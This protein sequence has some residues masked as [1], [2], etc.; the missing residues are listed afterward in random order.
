MFRSRYDYSRDD[1]LRWLESGVDYFY[2]KIFSMESS[3]INSWWGFGRILAWTP[4]NIANLEEFKEYFSVA[5]NRL[6]EKNLKFQ[7]VNYHGKPKKHDERALR[8]FS[9]YSFMLTQ[10]GKNETIDIINLYNKELNHHAR[11]RALIMAMSM[12]SDRN[13]AVEIFK[14]FYRIF[15]DRHIEI[16]FRLAPKGFADP[17]INKV[18][19]KTKLFDHL[20]FDKQSVESD[21]EIKNLLIKK[22]AQTPSLIEKLTFDINITY[23]NIENLPPVLRFNFIQRLFKCEIDTTRRGWGWTIGDGLQKRIQWKRK[24]TGYERLVVEQLTNEQIK[25]LLFPVALKKN[26][27]VSDWMREY[28]LYLL[29]LSSDKKIDFHDYYKNN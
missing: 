15:S 22:I 14:N 21:E 3:L 8:Y 10:K 4:D 26:K 16:L 7:H 1:F 2:I 9:N 28:N 17:D 18:L 6:L 13:R 23:K 19:Q 25:K 24:S 11:R 5:I 29:C 27:E 20:C 12:V